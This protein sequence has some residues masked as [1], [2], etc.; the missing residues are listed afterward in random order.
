MEGSDI[1]GAHITPASID[2]GKISVDNLSVISADMGDI[3]SGTITLD[4]AGHIKGGQTD[5]DTGDG[6]FVGNDDGSYKLSVGNTEK[7]IVWN[8]ENFIIRGGKVENLTAETTNS[9]DINSG[10]SININDGGDIMMRGDGASPAELRFYTTANPDNYISLYQD[11]TSTYEIIDSFTNDE[12]SELTV[13]PHALYNSG[14]SFTGNGGSVTSARFKLRRDPGARGE[15]T[16]KLYAHTGVFGTTGRPTGSLLAFSETLDVAAVGETQSW[17]E[18]FFTG[19]NIYTVTN[20]TKYVVVLE[21]SSLAGGNLKIGS[22]TIGAGNNSDHNGN[23]SVSTGGTWTPD[24]TRDMEFELYSDSVN[25]SATGLIFKSSASAISPYVTFEPNIKAD[26]ISAKTDGMGVSVDN[27]L[28][29][30]GDII[31]QV[32]SDSILE[33]TS[34]NGVTVDG[35]NIKDGKL[36]TANSVVT[37][38]ITDGNITGSKLATSAIALGYAEI[39]SNFVANTTAVTDVA[40]LSVTVTVPAGGRRIKIT[41]YSRAMYNSGVGGTFLQAYI[42]EGSTLLQQA[43]FNTPGAGYA[44]PLHM[45]Y[46]GI[47]TAG[48]HT[49]KVAIKQPVAAGNTMTLE[50]AST[51]P[52]FILVELI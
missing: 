24:E 12:I 49:Y 35:L 28:L 15:L 44:E 19:E 31:G 6:F 52:A 3:T 18:F 25:S 7:G 23:W 42:Y 34:A 9:I 22:S 48:S 11:S 45:M 13:T 17:V 36:N 2:A 5:F 30:E 46:S 10:A 27:V 38:N 43:V 4:S 14:Q 37:S 33:K 8:G 51:Y 47:P 1:N 29:R 21:V 50:A 20:G 26:T 16:A 40:G 39:T 32:V 41:V